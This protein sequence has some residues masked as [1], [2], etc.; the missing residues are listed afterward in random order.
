MAKAKK[1]SIDGEAEA[2]SKVYELGSHIVSSIPEEEVEKVYES[3]KDLITKA[4]GVIIAEEAPKLMDL[5]YVMVKH[6]H[7]KNVRHATAHFNWIKF[8][9]DPAAVPT[10]NEAISKN[11]HILRFIT[12]KTV[13]ESTLYG[14]KFANEAKEGKRERR[15]KVEEKPETAEP[16]PVSE[17][18]V[19]QAIEDIVNE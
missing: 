3:L 6:V 11:E 17:G 8:E 14:H 18:E 19:D 7:G 2:L 5:A 12:V 13:K 1:P 15:E 10:I 4:G 16:K 9:I